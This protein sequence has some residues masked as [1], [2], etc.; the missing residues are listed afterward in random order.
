MRRPTF[1]GGALLAATL[2]LAGC[3]DAGSSGTAA[4]A[5]SGSSGAAKTTCEPVAGQ[6]LVVLP[7]DKLLQTVD[8]LIPAINE[9]KSSEA[10]LA[11]VNKVSAALTT[12]DLVGLNKKADIERQS[13]PNVAKEFATTKGLDAAASGGSGTVTVGAANFSENQI[14]AN[15]YAIALDAA[16]FKAT[17]RTVGNR[18]VY[19]PELEKG[20]LT[21]VPEYA[22]TLTEFL[23]KKVNGA[24][25]K[26][27]A[28]SD[29]D[30]TAKELTALGAKVGL[31]FGEP[32][33]AAD[34]NAF[35]VT[36][37]FADKYGVTT[38]SDLGTKCGGLVLGGP[39]ECPERPFCQPGL[40]DTY[41]LQFASFKALDAGGPLTKNAL[42]QGQVALGLVF[43]SDGSLATS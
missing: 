16:G 2:V 39:P 41:G 17:V 37:A 26:A 29:L 14:V 5:S 11:A 42:K 33:Q 23:N 35:A 3:G 6:D 25:A 36:K 43:S 32:S 8:N 22:G 19:E 31:V 34:Q 28:S 1:L 18:E 12:D 20:S 21:V 15:L 27:K 9:K 13:P 30:A 38:L 7:D 4:P 10:L 40:T 24:D